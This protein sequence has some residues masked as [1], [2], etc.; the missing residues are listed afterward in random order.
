MA[1][2]PKRRK[3]DDPTGWALVVVG[4]GVFVGVPAW[5]VARAWVGAHLVLVVLV[6]VAVLVLAAALWLV[7]RA[8]RRA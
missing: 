1:R 6:A 8:R 7:V 4:L 5:R 3:K 2:R